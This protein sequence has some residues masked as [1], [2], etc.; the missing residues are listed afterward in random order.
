M[1]FVGVVG[2]QKRAAA[3]KASRCAR[4]PVRMAADMTKEETVRRERWRL[5]LDVMRFP[6]RVADLLLA[7][8]V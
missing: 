8:A 1:A 3:E 7:C 4:T 2:F 5:V 6:S